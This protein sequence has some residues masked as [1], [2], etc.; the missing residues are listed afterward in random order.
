MRIPTTK[1]QKKKSE[2]QIYKQWKTVIMFACAAK[3]KV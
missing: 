2:L 3:S 1:K